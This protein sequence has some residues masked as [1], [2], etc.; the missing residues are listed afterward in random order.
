[1]TIFA[2]AGRFGKVTSTSGCKHVIEEAQIL[3]VLKYIYIYTVLCCICQSFATGS[4]V[5]LAICPV[6]GS[7][8][9]KVCVLFLLF[10]TD[11]GN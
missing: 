10:S 6:H 5:H 1:M 9:V 7:K 8:I 2:S 3:N 4:T 11:S